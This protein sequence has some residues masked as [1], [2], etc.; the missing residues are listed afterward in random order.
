M[1]SYVNDVIKSNTC[2]NMLDVKILNSSKMLF[3]DANVSFIASSS[4]CKTCSC[5][6]SFRPILIL[7]SA[8]AFEHTFHV[9]QGGFFEKIPPNYTFVLTQ[10]YR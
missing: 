8:C 4:I 1:K 3:V 2:E 9:K 6:L 5:T 7:L 10:H